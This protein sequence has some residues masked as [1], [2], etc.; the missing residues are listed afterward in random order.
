MRPTCSERWNRWLK[1]L[2][3]SCKEKMGCEGFLAR[4]GP[5]SYQKYVLVCRKRSGAK[6]E[7]RG[8]GMSEADIV[9]GR[10]EWTLYWG[11]GRK[12]M[13]GILD[14]KPVW[15]NK[16]YFMFE[17]KSLS[18][19]ELW[20]DVQLQLGMSP[21]SF[22][23]GRHQ[24]WYC[25][26]QRHLQDHLEGDT[27]RTFWSQASARTPVKIQLCLCSTNILRD[28]NGRKVR[29]GFTKKVFDG[30]GRGGSHPVVNHIP[31]LCVHTL[32]KKKGLEKKH[33]PAYG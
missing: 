2:I 3:F 25:L 26:E 7:I 15:E 14:G 22:G 12:S 9:M 31:G 28:R 33:I 10:E 8:A 4:E 19:S 18:W 32:D 23:E 1:N 29:V 13:E 5:M 6:L 17:H 27:S 11:C 30:D 16:D 21:W 24:K 20:G